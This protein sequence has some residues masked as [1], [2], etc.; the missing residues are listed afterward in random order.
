MAKK[1]NTKA[2]P[3]AKNMGQ[4]KGRQVSVRFEE[5]QLQEVQD[6]SGQT[7][8]SVADLIR[9]GAL[10]FVRDTVRSGEITIKVR[11]PEEGVHI[12]PRD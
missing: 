10:E 9:R 8:I 6:L 7:G 11:R 12:G 3:I 5:S 1:T 2:A 4:T